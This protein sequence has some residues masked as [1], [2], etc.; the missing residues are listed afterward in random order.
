MTPPRLHVPDE[1]STALRSWRRRLALGEPLADVLAGPD[2]VAQW[3]WDRWQALGR[4]G[5]ARDAFDAQ[6]GDHGRELGLWLRGE[7]THA[8][9]ASS[10]AGRLSRRAR[11]DAVVH[12]LERT[13]L[14]DVA[15]T[16][17]AE[18][19]DAEA[20]DDAVLCGAVAS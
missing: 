11:P 19:S 4:L 1:P 20:S 7:R 6:V 15:P 9:V 17:D 2:G 5:V 18:A 16:S 8:S 13:G 14:G 12:G 3:Y 10:L